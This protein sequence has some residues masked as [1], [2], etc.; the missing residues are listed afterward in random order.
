[1]EFEMGPQKEA[2]MEP[3]MEAQYKMLLEL[4]FQVFYPILWFLMIVKSYYR[5]LYIYH[6]VNL[7]TEKKETIDETLEEV[8]TDNNKVVYTIHLDDEETIKN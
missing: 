2:E 5:S 4:L 1:M 8:T 3:E 6:L 7:E